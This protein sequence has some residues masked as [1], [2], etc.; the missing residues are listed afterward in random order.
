MTEATMY[1]AVT[2]EGIPQDAGYVA[3]YRNGRYAA[4]W[5]AVQ[6]RFPK[7]QLVGID[8][9]GTDTDA[10][11]LDVERYDATPQDVP[12]WVA[13]RLEAHP[14]GVLC[15]VY[16]NKY[17]WPQVRG[18]VSN[19]A[20][21]QRVAVRY[22]VADWTDEPHLPQGADACQYESTAKWDRSVIDVERFFPPA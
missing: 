20:P 13:R 16:C 15:R 4:D 5:D 11:V 19:L 18:Y 21:A 6:K 10:G 8:V 12:N 9:D 3:I 14:N 2:W 22:W 1:D 17:T 7:A